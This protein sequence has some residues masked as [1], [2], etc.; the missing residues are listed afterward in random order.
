MVIPLSTLDAC[1]VFLLDIRIIVINAV[2]MVPNLA[3]ITLN[4]V[5]ADLGAA[6]ML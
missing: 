4:H 5:I 2:E 1:V 6:A 3:I